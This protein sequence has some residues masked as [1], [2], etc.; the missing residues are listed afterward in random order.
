MRRVNFNVGCLVRSK[1]YQQL[2]KY[3]IKAPE[4]SIPHLNDVGVV[5]QVLDNYIVVLWQRLQKEGH[6]FPHTLEKIAD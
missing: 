2:R 5:V 6:H 1:P 4:K 3:G